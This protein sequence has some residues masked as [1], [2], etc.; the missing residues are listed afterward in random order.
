MGGFKANDN[1]VQRLIYEQCVSHDNYSVGSPTD[2]VGIWPDGVG[3]GGSTG[4][5]IRHCL[6]YNNASQGIKIEADTHDAK[7]YG[8][9]CRDNADA[10]IHVAATTPTADISGALIY[11][12]TC[13]D[14]WIGLVFTGISGR[15]DSITN[16]VCKN[17]I[18]L[19]TNGTNRSLRAFYGGENDGTMGSGNVY[20]KNA[21]GTEHTNFIEWGQ[22]VY[23]STYDAWL[24]ASSQT[25][26]N[27]ESDPSFTNAAGDDFSLA[28][29][30][31]CRDVGVD[32]GSPYNLALH[33]NS[34]WPNGVL[35]VD[36]D[37]HGV[38]WD[39]GA[40][41]YIEATGTIED[42]AILLLLRERK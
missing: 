23:Y 11:N 8:N 24:T 5:T 37:A 25:D 27:V 1:G 35:T 12:N 15:S 34:F 38:G 29:D 22:G 40:Y 28:S 31:P 16:C 32:L 10:G 13:V 18:S 4:P 41:V 17:N 36:Q 7:A 42:D 20:E 26:N 6:T 2:G 19:H 14:N 33:P 9:F 3:N 30:S 21:F 39:M